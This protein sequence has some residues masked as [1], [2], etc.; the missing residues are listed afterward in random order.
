MVKSGID[1]VDMGILH[2][3][4]K[5]ARNTTV[6][7]ISEHVNMA[8]STV[9]SRIRS[10]KESRVIKGYIPIIDYE[11]AGFDH[12]YIIVGTGPKPFEERDKFTEDL[13][14]VHGVVRVQSFSTDNN[15]IRVEVV[16]ET[17]Q[18]V[19]SDLAKLNELGLNIK[20]IEVIQQEKN[21]PFDHFGKHFT[22]ED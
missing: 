15:N 13:L 7:E 19:F 17:R 8:P 2:L 18:E 3:L 20:K 9:A 14:N 22:D 10:L 11:K 21:Q 5:D 16:G 1:P 12:K 6:E 4:Q